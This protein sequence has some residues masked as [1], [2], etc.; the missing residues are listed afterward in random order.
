M[1]IAGVKPNL[2]T[3]TALMS[4]CLSSGKPELAT[5]VF[6]RIDQPDGYAML[7][8]IRAMCAN[9]DLKD[10]TR[11]LAPQQS[12]RAEMSGRQVMEAFEI[13]IRSSLELGDFDTAKHTFVSCWV[14]YQRFLL[15][16]SLLCL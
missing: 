6:E 8:A 12:G 2:K 7:I 9:G 14:G 1:N 11:A 5:S 13:L 16:L 4:A 10:A 15:R 3:L